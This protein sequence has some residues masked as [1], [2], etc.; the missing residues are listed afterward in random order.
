MQ[1]YVFRNTKINY[2]R[3][4]NYE[5][6]LFHWLSSIEKYTSVN[7][8]IIIYKVINF[9]FITSILQILHRVT[10]TEVGSLNLKRY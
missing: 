5:Q 4:C 7:N 8:E 3:R 9:V 10:R 1:V 6:W 2:R